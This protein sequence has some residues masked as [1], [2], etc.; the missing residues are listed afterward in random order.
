LVEQID[1]E[2]K[3]IMNKIPEDLKTE[4]KVKVMAILNELEIRPIKYADRPF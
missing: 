2:E 1:K 3:N 4:I